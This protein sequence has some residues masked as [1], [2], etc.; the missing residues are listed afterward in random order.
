MLRQ[1]DG[2]DCCTVEASSFVTFGIRP[3]PFEGGA[4]AR[5]KVEDGMGLEGGGFS[6]LLSSALRA[7]RP[8]AGEFTISLL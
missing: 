4:E 8:Q 3:P 1:R 6:S 2:V 5:R 7:D